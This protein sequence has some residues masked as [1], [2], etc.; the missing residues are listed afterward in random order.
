LG[1]LF[2][3]LTNSPKS[4]HLDYLAPSLSI[5]QF[6]LA[7]IL[8]IDPA[9]RAH[10]RYSDLWLQ[11]RGGIPAV[12]CELLQVSS[13]PGH[14][15]QIVKLHILQGISVNGVLQLQ[16]GRC[17]RHQEATG[18]HRRGG[19]VRATSRKKGL[20][21]TPLVPKQFGPRLIGALVPVQ[22]KMWARKH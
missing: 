10:E 21:S 19:R 11:D 1:S 9:A 22:M 20:R 4:R 12:F 15:R 5:T 13:P 3:L 8:A 7:F 16:A 6:H 18:E 2:L 17:Q 14:L